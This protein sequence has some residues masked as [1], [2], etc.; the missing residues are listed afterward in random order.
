MLLQPLIRPDSEELLPARR[1]IAIRTSLGQWAA[2]AMLAA[3]VASCRDTVA[4]FGPGA[5]GRSAVDQLFGAFTE[6]YL[7]ITRNAKYEYARNQ[8]ARSALAPSRV[9]DDSATWTAVSGP[10]RML[11]T[12]GTASDEHYQMGSRRGVPA[13]QKPADGRHITT[14]SRIEEN[15]YRWD[16]NVDFALGSVRPD[17]VALVITRLLTAGEGRTE[18]ELRADIAASAPRTSAALAPL[19]TLDSLRPVQLADGSTA[20]ALTIQ[21]HSD[22]IRPRFPA[23]AEYVRKYVDP[24]RL[25]FKVND[26][27]GATYVDGQYRDR[28]L[29][30]R[31]RSFNGRLVPLSGVARPIPD[32]LLLLVDFTMKVKLFHVGFH[33]LSLDFV[34]ASHGSMRDWTVT[35]H[36]EPQWNLP[37]ITA[38]LLRAPLRYPFAGEGALFRMGVRAGEDDRPTVLVRQ[39]RLGVQESAILRF[40]NSLT[41]T[42]MDDFGVRVERDQNLWL[43]EL[44]SAMRDDMRAALPP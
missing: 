13:P 44:F 23:L 11:E 5:R 43:R 16:T 17:D 15:Q 37:F 34:N 36:R 18:R 26:R 2:I 29:H 30:L 22:Q 1:S 38:R 7:D 31:V 24:A 42:A 19:F 35:G 10:V 9:F 25:R 14:L 33:D 39:A 8:I 21:V 40:L 41:S 12:F 32:T 20:V 3:G 4:G 27:A 6:R 28:V